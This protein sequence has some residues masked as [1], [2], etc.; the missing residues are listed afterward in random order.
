MAKKVHNKQKN[1]KENPDITGKE[2]LVMLMGLA[3][4]PNTSR[5]HPKATRFAPVVV[6]GAP[7]PHL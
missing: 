6:S 4:R 2:C 1:R 7:I 5:Q 3:H